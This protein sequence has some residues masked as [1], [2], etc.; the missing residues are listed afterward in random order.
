LGNEPTI[1]PYKCVANS[2]SSQRYKHSVVAYGVN[3]TPAIANTPYSHFFITGKIEWSDS[4]VTISTP[5]LYPQLW[6]RS[7]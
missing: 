2:D 3:L 1:V 5:K 6:P 7:C 4:N